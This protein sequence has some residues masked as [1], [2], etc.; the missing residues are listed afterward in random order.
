MRSR[1][2]L[3]LACCLLVLPACQKM[4]RHPGYK[5]LEPSNFFADGRSSRPLVAGTVARGQ[6]RVDTALYEGKDEKGNFVTEFPFAIDEGVLER[7]QSRYNVFCAVC[8]NKTGD[9]NGRIVQRGFTKPPHLITDNSRGYSIKSQGRDQIS[10]TAVPVGY[11]YEVITKGY[12]AMPSYN[13]QISVK[14]R[15]AITAYVRALQ[16]ADSP[17]FRQNLELGQAKDKEPEKVQDKGEKKK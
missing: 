10:L 16:Y 1:K 5:P 14:D 2:F 6:A 3:L 9:G 7:G 13:E 11:I 15:W 8:H 4:A 17:A 12:G